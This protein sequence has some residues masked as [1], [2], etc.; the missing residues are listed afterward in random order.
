MIQGIQERIIGEILLYFVPDLLRLWFIFP[1]L[2][3][4]FSPNAYIDRR[5][6]TLRSVL[7]F[8][9]RIGIRNK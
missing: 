4:S 7:L 8:S 6:A 9:L 1:V 5:M 3:P 2:E